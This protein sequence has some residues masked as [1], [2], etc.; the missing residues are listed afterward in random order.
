[1]SHGSHRR[2]AVATLEPL[3]CIRIDGGR[4]LH[5]QHP[6]GGAHADREAGLAEHLEHLVVGGMHGR[7]EGADPLAL[8][9]CGE[10]REQDRPDAA[11]VEIIGDLERDLRAV[12][13]DAVIDGVAGHALGIARATRPKLRPRRISAAA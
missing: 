4:H 6:T 7:H 5:V 3:A 11:S 1:M 13:V 10:M 12:V 2:D 8:S 9:R